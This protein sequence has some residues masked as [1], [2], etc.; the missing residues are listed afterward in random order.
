M[1]YCKIWKLNR[2]LRKP[3]RKITFQWRDGL[4]TLAEVCVLKKISWPVKHVDSV[5]LDLE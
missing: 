2:D 3:H 1:F 4:L 5:T